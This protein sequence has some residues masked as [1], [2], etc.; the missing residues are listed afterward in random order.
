MRSDTNN[1]YEMYVNLAKECNK[2][3]KE[4]EDLRKNIFQSHI[5]HCN[6][7]DKTSKFNGDFLEDNI[8]DFSR[9]IRK[10]Y[11]LGIAPTRTVGKSWVD[12]DF[13]LNKIFYNIRL[14]TGG[15]PLEF[16]INGKDISK[17]NFY[18][19]MEIDKL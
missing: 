10:L 14:K 1:Y 4:N 8:R 7:L 16:S 6:F 18:K 9:H 11:K 12:L 3:E 2:L 5:Q 13:I 15:D 19:K 17:E